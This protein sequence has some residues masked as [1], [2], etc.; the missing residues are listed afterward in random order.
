MIPVLGSIA[1]QHA[2]PMQRTLDKVKLFLD[3]ATTH[4]NAIVMY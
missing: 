1:T 4:P 3:Y 2:N